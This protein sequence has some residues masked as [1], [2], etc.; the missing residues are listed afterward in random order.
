MQLPTVQTDS[1]VILARNSRWI[2][3]EDNDL[4]GKTIDYDH[5]LPKPQ[6]DIEEFVYADDWEQHKHGP[7]NVQIH[8]EEDDSWKWLP[9]GFCSAPRSVVERGVVW[10]DYD[11]VAEDGTRVVSVCH[12]CIDGTQVI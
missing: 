1:G 9:C 5:P 12:A 7:W 4:I 2:V 6:G 11:L 8:E 3:Q 10:A